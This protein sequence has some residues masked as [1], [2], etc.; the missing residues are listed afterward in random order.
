MNDEIKV[1]EQIEVSANDR[2][3]WHRPQMRKLDAREAETTIIGINTDIVF[4]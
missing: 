3:E 4:S 1:A 2:P